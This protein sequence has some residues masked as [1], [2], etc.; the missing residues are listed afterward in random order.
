MEGSSVSLR[1][2]SDSYGAR[3]DM[4]ADRGTNRANWKM[5]GFDEKVIE[6][7][8]CEIDA[9]SIDRFSECYAQGEYRNVFVFV[10]QD[11]RCRVGDNA[12]RHV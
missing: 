3:A 8:M 2:E 9:V 7:M 12:N 10:R 11:V 5:V 1:E 6:L 4:G